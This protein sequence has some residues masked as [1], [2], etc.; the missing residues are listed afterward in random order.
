MVALRRLLQLIPTLIGVSLLTFFLMRLAP[1]DPVRLMLG[2]EASPEAV[3]ELRKQLGFD[4]PLPV[5]YLTYMGLNFFSGKEANL[6]E[7]AESGA[8][9]V[10]VAAGHPIL[11][12]DTL[13]LAG[14]EGEIRRRV[15]SATKDGLLGLDQPLPA[16]VA[17][18][19]PVSVPWKR[20][21]LQGNFGTSIVRE[22]PVLKEIMAR[23]P[24]TIELAGAA[25]C[26]AIF[27]GLLIGTLSS[28]Y[29]GS[30][31]EN[32]TRLFVFVF[33][34]MP[35]F[36]LALEL[37]IIFARTLEW[38]PPSG[39]GDSGMQDTLRHLVLPAL[40]LGL[41]TGAFLSRILRSSMV[42][43][44][45][46][47][48][49]RTARA[50]GLGK[51]TVVMKHA[52]KNAMIPFV[53]VAG[54]SMG[55]LLGGSVIVESV[56]NWPGVGKLFVDSILQRDL[57]VTMGCVLILATI[58]VVVNLLVDL[59]YTVLDPRIRLEGGGGR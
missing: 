13:V 36:W 44:L 55:S 26:V 29:P 6:S 40:S 11:R 16:P 4:K 35:G 31:F 19:S 21:V 5:Q 2:A 27:I 15:T 23:L 38:F 25:M 30:W 46:Q 9:A 56:F 28:V 51:F 49:V 52:L 1:G 45:G 57:P 17:A 54:L 39:R 24:A 43:V 8:K 48:Y 41:G 37:I 18:G 14:P 58:F 20:G 32:I 22:G 50:K 33:L 47:D 3:E 42:Q 53:T 10:R 59:L 7:A 34:A 12:N